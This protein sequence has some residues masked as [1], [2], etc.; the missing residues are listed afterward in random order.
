MKAAVQSKVH[1][2][3]DFP[4]QYKVIIHMLTADEPD[5]FQKSTALFKAEQI[6]ISDTVIQE[7]EWVLRYA[8]KFSAAQITAALRALFGLPNVFLPNPEAIDLAL[9][10][11]ENGLDFSDALHLAQAHD[12]VKLVTFDKSFIMRAQELATIHVVML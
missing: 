9:T 4:T 5:Q 2:S 12:C 8:Y 1:S 3:F 6:F 10:W 7:T 11:H